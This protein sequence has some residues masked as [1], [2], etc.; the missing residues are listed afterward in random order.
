[1]VLLIDSADDPR[2]EQFRLRERELR[3]RRI[4][5]RM[6][7][8]MTPADLERVSAGHFVAEGDLVVERAVAAGCAPVALLTDAESPAAVATTMPDHVPVFAARAEARR[9]LTGLGVALDVIGLFERPPVMAVEDLVSSSRHL[10]IAE[11]V[12]NPT[13]IGAIARSAAAF[14]VDGLVL[15]RNSAD[16]LARRALRV[17]M[18]TALHMRH[19]RVDGIP[20]IVPLLRAHGFVVCGLT[21]HASAA[22]IAEVGRLLPVSARVAIVLGSERE[23]LSPE[24]LA[25]IDHAVRIPMAPGIDSLNVAAAAAVACHSLLARTLPA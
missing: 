25:A 22:D 13:N 17:S 19:S 12:D 2:L 7:K 23:G 3:P 14:G 24:T 6:A 21:P 16:P 18:G 4:P 9:M 1:V 11:D 8:G 10:L 20:S 15:D 5:A